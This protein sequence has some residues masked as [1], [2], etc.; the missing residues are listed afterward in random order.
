[1]YFELIDNDIEN[2]EFGLK[3]FREEYNLVPKSKDIKRY[4][5]YLI[6]E[7]KKYCLIALDYKNKN[8]MKNF[9]RIC[10][11]IFYFK[12]CYVLNNTECI[13]FQDEKYQTIENEIIDLYAE[14]FKNYLLGYGYKN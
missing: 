8:D 11:I 1:M 14:S 10:I 12:H 9:I 7:F 13:Y 3:N 2:L 4:K 5:E 6:R